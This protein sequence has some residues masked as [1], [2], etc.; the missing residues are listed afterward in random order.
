MDK[1]V[2]QKFE[3]RLNENRVRGVTRVNLAGIILGRVEAGRGDPRYRS[4]CV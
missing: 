3:H 4:A 1:A 2:S